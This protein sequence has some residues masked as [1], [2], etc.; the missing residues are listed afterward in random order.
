MNKNKTRKNHSLRKKINEY[1]LK[2]SDICCEEDLERNEVIDK[3]YKNYEKVAEMWGEKDDYLSYIVNDIPKFIG[4]KIDLEKVKDKQGLRLWNTLYNSTVKNK[5]AKKDLITK[6]L[7]ELP[8]YYLLA[9]L[10]YSY[11]KFP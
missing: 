4:Y 7:N 2:K 10:G 8:L 5:V 3:I 9:I 6:T 11:C 1:I